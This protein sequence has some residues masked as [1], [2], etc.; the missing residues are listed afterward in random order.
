MPWKARGPSPRSDHR[1]GRAGNS[2]AWL[3]VR[4]QDLPEVA[5]PMASS[6]K[7]VLSGDDARGQDELVKPGRELRLS[8]PR[9][10]GVVCSHTY[11][12]PLQACGQ[13]ARGRA[14]GAGGH[15]GSGVEEDLLERAGQVAVPHRGSRGGQRMAGD[16]DRAMSPV[17]AGL[18]RQVAPDE[19][20][21]MAVRPVKTAAGGR[22][23]RR[24]RASPAV[25]A[26]T[27][28]R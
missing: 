16:A 10:E 21:V 19:I 7:L 2:V 24:R 13:P 17:S 15:A 11:A 1:C 14:A 23:W 5:S 8:L 22:R 6:V 26:G 20:P 25:S 18:S 3:D 12:I 28:G 27:A 4:R 9:I